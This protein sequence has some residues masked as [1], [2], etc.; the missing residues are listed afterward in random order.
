MVPRRGLEP[1]HPCEYQHLKLARLPIPPSGHGYAIG[2]QLSWH[3]AGVNGF[4]LEFV[5]RAQE[6]A[7]CRNF[8]FLRQIVWFA[9]TCCWVYCAARVVG[10]NRQ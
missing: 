5:G 8:I 4:I 6:L 9:Q 7:N 1:P 2:R 10:L 3:G